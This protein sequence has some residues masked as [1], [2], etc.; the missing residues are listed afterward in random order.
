[1]ELSHIEWFAKLLQLSVIPVVLISGVGLL[2]LS[3]TNRLAR[4]IDR[5]RS[6]AKQLRSISEEEKHSANEQLEILIKRSE[7]LRTAITFIALSILFSSLMIIGLFFLLFVKWPT[8][9]IVLLFFFISV[10]SVIISMGF[11][12]MDIFLTLRA[13]KLELGRDFSKKN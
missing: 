12:L 13:L 9:H 1:M 8:E 4:T 6:L 11:F 2:L 5:S 10:L 7:L 3:F